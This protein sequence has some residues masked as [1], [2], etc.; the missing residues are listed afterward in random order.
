MQPCALPATSQSIAHMRLHSMRIRPSQLREQAL[1]LVAATVAAVVMSRALDMKRVCLFASRVQESALKELLLV[2]EDDD[3]DG[4]RPASSNRHYCRHLLRLRYRCWC[5]CYCCCCCRHRRH[6]AARQHRKMTSAIAF[7]VRSKPASC[8]A[9]AA[10]PMTFLDCHYCY[11]GCCCCC[12]NLTT[13]MPSRCDRVHRCLH[14]GAAPVLSL[15]RALL[16]MLL[17]SS[18]L[19]LLLLLSLLLMPLLQLLNDCFQ[20]HR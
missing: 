19:L 14:V 10:A 11:C 5:C 12:V 9:S 18:L 17:S 20:R 6:Q 15:P 7:V 2:D 13:T 3:G 8:H 4:H 1:L 16:P